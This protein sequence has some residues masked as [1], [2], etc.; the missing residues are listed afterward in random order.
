MPL[1]VQFIGSSDFL[2][3]AAAVKLEIKSKADW[4]RCSTIVVAKTIRPRG[5]FLRIIRSCIGVLWPIK[6]RICG[7]GADP[8]LGLERPLIRI[9]SYTSLVTV[10]PI[11]CPCSWRDEYAE[12]RDP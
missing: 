5:C 11:G 8:D 3:D 6:R 2:S 9:G 4:P 12:A 10:W 1:Y 7:D